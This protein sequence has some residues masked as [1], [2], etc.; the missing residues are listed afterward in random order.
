M[1]HKS[2]FMTIF[3][4]KGNIIMLTV[5]Y[6]YM[7]VYVYLYEL[8]MRQQYLHYIIVHSMLS[9]SPSDREEPTKPNGIKMEKFVFDVFQFAK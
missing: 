9:L 7:Y 6:M 4:M 5:L 2:I 1:L 8:F 3:Y